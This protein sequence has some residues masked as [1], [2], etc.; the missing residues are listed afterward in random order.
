LCRLDGILRDIEELARTGMMG[1][2]FLGAVFGLPVASATAAIAGR[3]LALLPFGVSLFLFFAWWS[4]YAAPG[5]AASG[6]GMLWTFLLTAMFGWALIA[7]AVLQPWRWSMWRAYRELLDP[8][9]L[10]GPHT[11]E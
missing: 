5:G 11:T 3:L 6:P 8:R 7:F 1:W 10:F 4:Y 2:V 9:P